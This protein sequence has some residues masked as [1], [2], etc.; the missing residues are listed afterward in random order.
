MPTQSAP[1]AVT[2]ATV[3]DDDVTRYW[4][5]FSYSADD[6]AE[7][8]AGCRHSSETLAF[9]A[10]SNVKDPEAAARAMVQL[11]EKVKLTDDTFE[12]MLRYTPLSDAERGA[13]LEN[14]H[15]GPRLAAHWGSLSDADKRDALWSCALPAELIAAEWDRNPSAALANPAT[16]TATLI[17]LAE[18]FG[19]GD[20]PDSILLLTHP[21]APAHWRETRPSEVADMLGPVE[22]DWVEPGGEELRTKYLCADE[23]RL[24]VVPL[25]RD[26]TDAECEA[27]A[28]MVRAGFDGTVGELL[29][30]ARTFH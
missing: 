14:F 15:S 8:I 6:V 4:T 10:L 22:A 12:R 30:V 28:S 18:H 7:N 29:D 20:T 23:L 11:L 25:I 17:E 19:E 2:E 5:L 1:A 13:L 27:A 24:D 26:L 9:A 16:P 21:N 3:T